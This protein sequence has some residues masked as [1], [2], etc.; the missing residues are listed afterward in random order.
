MGDREAEEEEDD[1]R[2]ASSDSLG[3]EVDNEVN[4]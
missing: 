1:G 2:E 4:F 3:D